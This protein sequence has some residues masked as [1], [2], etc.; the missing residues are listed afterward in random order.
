MNA[1][2]NALGGPGPFVWLIGGIALCAAEMFA[3]GIFLLWIGFAAVTLGL[4]ELLLP[5]S[6]AWSLLIFAVLAVIY[7]LLGRYV[8]G[9]RSKS[10]PFELNARAANLIGQEFTLLAPLAN[11]EGTIRVHDSVWRVTGPD[12]DAGTRV[13][14]AG[15]R[16]AVVLIV[17]PA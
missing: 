12:A 14:V 2:F 6:L 17:E 7:C 10:N 5:I 13:R 8:Y 9:D 15:V 3:P 11:G 4:I 16:D 1:L